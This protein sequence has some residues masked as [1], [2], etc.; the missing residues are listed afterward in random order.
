MTNRMDD[1]FADI[2]H[3]NHISHLRVPDFKVTAD[4]LNVLAR[5]HFDATVRQSYEWEAHQ[6]EAHHTTGSDIWRNAALGR[7][8]L[9]AIQAVLGEEATSRAVEP[10]RQKWKRYFDS[11][12]PG[13]FDE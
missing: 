8:R 2:N 3:V 7:L 4:E 1:P 5:H 13:G 11:I 9:A 10:S 12:P 6:W